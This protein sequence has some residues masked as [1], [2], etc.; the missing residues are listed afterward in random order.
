MLLKHPVWKP[1]RIAG[2]FYII[3]RLQSEGDELGI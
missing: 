1:E 3:R 2:M